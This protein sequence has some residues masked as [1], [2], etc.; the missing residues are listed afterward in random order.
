LV[1]AVDRAL[2]DWDNSAGCD[3]NLLLTRR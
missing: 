1:V 2:V 3:D